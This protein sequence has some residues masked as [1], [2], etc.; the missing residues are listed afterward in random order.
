MMYIEQFTGCLA[1]GTPV[2][3]SLQN[4]HRKYPDESLA[5]LR[6]PSLNVML[7]ISSFN[8]DSQVAFLLFV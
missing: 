3:I 8:Q 2:F 4:V 5:Q 7:G 6:S 1:T